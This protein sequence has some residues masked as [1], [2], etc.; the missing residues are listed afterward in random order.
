MLE[1]LPHIQHGFI[2]LNKS[3]IGQRRRIQGHVPVPPGARQLDD[4]GGGVG[5][6][7]HTGFGVCPAMG[8]K[9]WVTRVIQPSRQNGVGP[10]PTSWW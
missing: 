10:V 1:T 2:K 9:A 8:S 3:V 7:S 6:R 4:A 5:R